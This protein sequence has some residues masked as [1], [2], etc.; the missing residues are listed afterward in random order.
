MDR[1]NQTVLTFLSC[2]IRERDWPLVNAI[3]EKVLRPMGFKCVTVGRNIS[4]PQPA[5]DAIKRV[6]A[7][8]E[9]LI[10]IATERYT[11]ADADFPTRTL[12]LATPYLVQE[13]AMAFQGNLPFLIF[14]VSGVELEGVT[15]KNL[16][17]NIDSA[18]HGD[19]PKFLCRKEAL[20]SALDDL[21]KR[22]LALRAKKSRDGIVDWIK[23]A[24]LVVVGGYSAYRLIDWI[25][26]PGC[27]GNYYYLAP[28]CRT[29]ESKANC[30]AEKV[31]RETAK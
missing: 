30:K 31:R 3:E 14:R 10:G 25:T 16:Y 5:D 13:T 26:T 15:R 1:S 27:F 29:C 6:L 19:R 24:G 17:I 11:A 9:C 7:K 12:T 2:S 22:A 23:N 28:Q 18:L 20:Y 4:F 21:R 8:C